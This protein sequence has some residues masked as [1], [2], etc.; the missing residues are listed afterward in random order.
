MTEL[1]NRRKPSLIFTSVARESP[2]RRCLDL[3]H[4]SPSSGHS[5]SSS[6]PPHPAAARQGVVAPRCI[7]FTDGRYAAASAR[8]MA[9]PL[10][11]TASY[12]AGLSRSKVKRRLNRYRRS[13]DALKRRRFAY[14]AYRVALATMA[15]IASLRGWLSCGHASTTRSSSSGRTNFCEALCEAEGSCPR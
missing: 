5:S 8:S 14:S 6:E 11:F 9:L 10:T 4:P 7:S 1:T 15:R 13:S 3:T 2:P 12:E